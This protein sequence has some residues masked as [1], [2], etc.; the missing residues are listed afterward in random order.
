MRKQY[1]GV[2]E[3]LNVGLL[4]GYDNIQAILTTKM[5]ATPNGNNFKTP[6]GWVYF[7]RYRSTESYESE[8]VGLRYC[9][10]ISSV[11]LQEDEELSQWPDSSH[12]TTIDSRDVL[13]ILDQDFRDID[14]QGK[15]SLED[16]QFMEALDSG[17]EIDEKNNVTLPLPFNERVTELR[18]NYPMVFNRLLSLRR[19]LLEDERVYD[20]YNKFMN[21]MINSGYA[22]R[23]ESTEL[24]AVKFYIPHHP[25][26]ERR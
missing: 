17:L 20:S 1:E 12:S 18:N 3:D 16:Y 24:G 26:L 11:K 22:R 13:D 6:L 14:V 8:D 9:N 25:R 10:K 23:L 2:P 15:A 19:K 7:G 4:L 21:E 5:K